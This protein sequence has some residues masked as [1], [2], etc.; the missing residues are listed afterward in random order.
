MK[1]YPEFAGRGRYF[2]FKS[3]FIP[4][5]IDYAEES[6]LCT[7]LTKDGFKVRT[8]EHLLSALEAMG[9]DNCRI[10]IENVDA[11]DSEVE[12]FHDQDIEFSLLSIRENLV[13]FIFIYRDA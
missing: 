6:P 13:C 3:N 12:V 1:L 8:V 11:E 4:A 10:E 7:T 5:S 9:V 2:D